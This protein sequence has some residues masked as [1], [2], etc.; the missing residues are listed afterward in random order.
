MR[1]SPPR[2]AATWQVPEP[3]PEAS[4]TILRGLKDKY[5]SHHGVFITDGALVAAV[6]HA[7]R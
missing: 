2:G 1:F 7:H 5:Q 4:L 3:S 6:Q